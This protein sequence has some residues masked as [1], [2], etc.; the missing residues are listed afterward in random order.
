V[1]EDAIIKFVH[2]KF[3]V[4]SIAFKVKKIRIRHSRGNTEMRSMYLQMGAQKDHL[5]QATDLVW[6]PNVCNKAFIL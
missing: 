2:F 1:P 6:P 4:S 5:P 3:L